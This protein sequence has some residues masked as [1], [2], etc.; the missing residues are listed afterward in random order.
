MHARRWD[1]LPRALR[2]RGAA[3]FSRH[4]LARH[5]L[6]TRR[7]RLQY[8][9]SFLLNLLP[10][11]LPR[12]RSSPR[13]SSVSRGQRVS[14]HCVTHPSLLCRTE[15]DVTQPLP[16]QAFMVLR[17]ANHS[18]TFGSVSLCDR[19]SAASLL[20][21]RVADDSKHVDQQHARTSDRGP[22][23]KLPCSHQPALSVCC[24]AS[25]FASCR[26]SL[27]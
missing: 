11:Y 10:P 23:T 15:Q 4:S 12:L 18:V 27:Q 22:S 5:G 16:N 7:P 8:T 9:P 13:P 17:V 26:A 25:C 20:L 2:S 1:G 6:E 19:A 3:L 24:E 21:R 14:E